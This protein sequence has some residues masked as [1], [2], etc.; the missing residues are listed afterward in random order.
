MTTPETLSLAGEH[1]NL[2]ADRF[3]SNVGGDFFLN[4]EGSL[5]GS[6]WDTEITSDNDVDLH[7]YVIIIYLYFTFPSH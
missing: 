5:T 6:A 1:L 3:F 2:A 4:T 7:V